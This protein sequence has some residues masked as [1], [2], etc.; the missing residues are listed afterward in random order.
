MKNPIISIL[1]P[2]CNVEKY[3]RECL[4]SIQKQTYKNIEVIC[5]ND[6]SKDSTG[7]IIDE[8]VAKDSRFKV[9]HK[10]NSGYG[11][12]M[13]KGLEVAT[14]DYIGIIES[15]DWIEPD[16]FETLYKTAEGNN[17]D[18]TRCCWFEGP[19]GTEKINDQGWVKKNTVYCPL[20]YEATLLQQPA[21]W[22][23]L[24]KRELLEEGRKVRFLPTPGASYQ[25]TSFAFKTYTKSKRFMMIDRCLHHYRINPSSSVSSSGKVFCISDEWEE[26]IRWILEDPEM[27]ERFTK[28]SLLPDIFC[29]GF[30]W[31]Y[32]R[33]SMLPRMQFLHR[34]STIFRLAHTNGI[35]DISK[36]TDKKN[37]NSLHMVMEN[38]LLYHQKNTYEELDKLYSKTN[39]SKL[40]SSSTD[41]VTIIVPCYNTSK[42]IFV[43]LESCLR[44]N[45]ENLEILCVDDCSTD[46]TQM[47]VRHIMRRDKRVSLLCTEKNSG[48]SASR[49]LGLKHSNGNYILF[50]DGDD[51]LMP[52]AIVSL[53]NNMNNN[54]DVVAASAN[55]VY[56]GGRD[57]YGILPESDDKYY[58]IHTR[59]SIDAIQ[60]IK[61]SK[62]IHVSAW[63]KLWRLDVIKKYNISF[64]EGYL[65]E[66]A[67]FYWKYLSVAPKLKLI[68]DRVYVYRRH[69]QGSIMSNTFC[70]KSGMS[71][72]HI[73]ILNDMYKFFLEHKKEK[74]GTKILSQVYEPYFRFAYNNAP[75]DDYDEIFSTMCHI[76]KVQKADVENIP[77]LNYVSRY[78]DLSKAQLFM[79]A[80]ENGGFPTPAN[81]FAA[82]EIIRLNRKYKK[83]KRLTNQMIMLASV[84]LV[85]LIISLIF[86]ISN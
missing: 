86:L 44:Q 69:I 66:D 48:L 13:N 82:P 25:D 31:N 18:L 43:A 64:C 50:L 85:S 38:P 26:M 78:D 45:Y 77:I 28:S 81:T 29:G 70:K 30:H 6:G 23:S 74:E 3:V 12:S 16:M 75:E 14:G 84:L 83:Y 20:D 60:Q 61:E 57:K 7:D 73:Y 54:I 15:D 39:P 33:L 65:Y 37:R 71:V 19:T 53:L 51:Y 63:A 56:E 10:S 67:N 24:Y 11:D 27:K 1:V 9:I 35:F 17:L 49:N 42:Y 79:K 40:E 21:I 34:A 55:V 2:C 52:N 68:V 47:L 76:L 36:M 80:Y 32:N 5:I 72:H 4:G 62:D 41:L 22:A 46:E 58:K 8:F 59:K